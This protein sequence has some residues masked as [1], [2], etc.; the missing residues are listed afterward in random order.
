M[1]T[2]RGS[3]N[4]PSGRPAI[5]TAKRPAAAVVIALALVAAG[6]AVLLVGCYDVTAPQPTPQPTGPDSCRYANDGV[7]DEPH[8]CPLNTDTTDCTDTQPSFGAQTVADQAYTVGEAIAELVLPAATGGEAPLRYRLTPAVPGLSFNSSTRTLSGTPTAAAEGT[9]AMTYRVEDLDGDAATLTFTVQVNPA[10]IADT[11]PSFGLQTVSD[12]T[13]WVGSS[14]RYLALPEAGGGNPPLTYSLTPEVP[15]LWFNPITLIVGGTPTAAAE[16]VHAMTYR[17]E[18]VDG[19]FAT[20]TF[21]LRIDVDTEPNFGAQTVADQAYTVGE[22]IAELVLPAAT[23]GEAPLRYRLTP[24]VPGLSFNPSTRTLSGTPTAAGSYSMTYTVTDEDGDSDETLFAITVATATTWGMAYVENYL[25]WGAPK[26]D[27]PSKSC[28]A[29][30]WAAGTTIIDTSDE[31]F[32]LYGRL[33]NWDVRRAL[34]GPE[35]DQFLSSLEGQCGDD[36]GPGA[37]YANLSMFSSSRH[38][39]AA[40]YALALA[41]SHSHPNLYRDELCDAGSATA[42][43]MTAAQEQALYSCGIF[44]DGCKVV[45]AKCLR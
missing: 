16:G 24:A 33:S 4:E 28:R 17:V 42:P 30:N 44:G 29:R 40:C 9:H 26:K 23:G 39:G 12:Q 8:Y 20:L 7:C 43:T 6:S 31:F 13:F 25:G 19:D 2:I 5:V 11:E 3:R 22:A 1:G 18:D 36:C 45:Y 41:N 32:S 10:P 37:T 38:F 21:E 35:L 27:H 14:I 15:G 34:A